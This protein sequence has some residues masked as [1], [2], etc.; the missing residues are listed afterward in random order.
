MRYY[1]WQGARLNAPRS[2]TIDCYRSAVRLDPRTLL[3]AKTVTGVAVALM[4]LWLR[5]RVNRA[6]HRLRGNRLNPTL[7]GEYPTLANDTDSSV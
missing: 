4:P 7:V 2:W 5:Q 6:G 1:G 3:R